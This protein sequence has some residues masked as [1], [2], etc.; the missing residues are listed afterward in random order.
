[1]H[2]ILVIV[3][4]AKD[5]ILGMF[6]GMIA[7]LFDYSKAKRSGDKEFIF[8]YS[9]LFI[10]IALG[11]FVGYI[12]GTIIDTDMRYR[13]AIIAF[14]GVSAYNILLLTENRFAAII[15]NKILGDKK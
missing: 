12:A 3:I 5:L 14:S 6:G 2:D 15:V 7:Y 8:I 10:N 11:A 4:G 1:M 13:D 9:S